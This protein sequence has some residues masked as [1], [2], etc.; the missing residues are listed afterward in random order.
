MLQLGVLGLLPAAHW[1][2]WVAL[3][4]RSF[5]LCASQ[6]GLRDSAAKCC[7]LEEQLLA[8]RLSEGDKECQLKEL[9]YS[10]RALEQELQSLRLQVTAWLVLGA[11][12]VT[13][14]QLHEQMRRNKKSLLETHSGDLPQ[15]CSSPA[16]QTSTDELSSRYVEMINNLREDKDRE[17]RNL[18]VSRLTL[19][20]SCPA[21]CRQTA[22][23]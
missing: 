15:A 23:L 2:V 20:C 5:P 22:A 13:R 19:G 17:I 4:L 7:S 21:D 6:Q 1:G 9:E 18:R 10:K 16:L 14:A 3:A 11:V 12:A 8:L